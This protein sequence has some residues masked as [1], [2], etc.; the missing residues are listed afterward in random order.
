MADFYEDDE[1]IIMDDMMPMGPGGRRGG[2]GRGAGP[3]DVMF[4][5]FVHPAPAAGETVFLS[6]N[7]PELTN[8]V[9]MTV[10]PLG[11]GKL[12]TAVVQVNAANIVARH[13]GAASS[14]AAGLGGMGGML[15][16]LGG[17][18]DMGGMRGAGGQPPTF[19]Y[20]Y[21]VK[22]AAGR[23]THREDGERNGE[24][25]D[26]K[27]FYFHRAK[28]AGSDAAQDEGFVHFVHD[29][30][31]Q[32]QSGNI[33]PE[34][35]H[36]RLMALHS[37]K[38]SKQGPL[39]DKAIEDLINNHW[40][41][42]NAPHPQVVLQVASALG[43]IR[44]SRSAM[45]GWGMPHSFM[46]DAGPAGREKDKE[47]EKEEPPS[48]LVCRW[49][50]K[51]CPSREELDALENADAGARE[52]RPKNRRSDA[53]T[54]NGVR[55]AAET[56]YTKEQTFEWLKL[57]NFLQLHS[58]PSAKSASEMT[59][60][61]SKKLVASFVEEMET[62]FGRIDAEITALRA[63]PPAD[64]KE[65]QAKEAEVQRKS[66]MYIGG[67]CSF[68]PSA[69]SLERL[70]KRVQ[71][72]GGVFME[73]TMQNVF[74][75][76]RTLHFG[77]SDKDR[78]K[79]MIQA[80]PAMQIDECA[81]ALLQ[82][83]HHPSDSKFDAKEIIDFV[84]M[85]TQ[86]RQGVRPAGTQLQNAA[87]RWLVR[88]YGRPSTDRERKQDDKKELGDMSQKE[89]LETKKEVTLVMRE[90]I[91][92]WNMV[93]SV[94][95]F[96][97]EDETVRNLLFELS[98]SYFFKDQQPLLVLDCILD[99]E[100][101]IRQ[102]TVVQPLKI[103]VTRIS[104]KCTRDA[105]DESEQEHDEGLLSLLF[106][107]PTQMR[108]DVIE[109]FMGFRQAS[110]GLENILKN[111][112]IWAHLLQKQWL[113]ARDIRS[114]QLGNTQD[115]GMKQLKD[116]ASQLAKGTI[117]L[118]ALH[119]IIKYQANYESLVAQVAP[120]PTEIP[121]ST[122]KIRKFDEEFE[123]LQ[124]YVKMFCTIAQID[125]IE[126]S[127]LVEGINR[128]Y[129][130]LE[131]NKAAAK[132][133]GLPVR[134]HLPWLYS[135]RG[136]EVFAGI[137]KQ[138][139]RP[140][141]EADKREIKQDEVV[142]SII[143]EA[144][145]CWELLSKNIETGQAI[146]NDIRWVVNLQWVSVERE[147][148]LLHTTAP[149]SG[150]W[151]L[152]SGELCKSMRLAAKLRD[153]APGL[154]H[155]HELLAELF[156]KGGGKDE[157]VE[158]LQKV[159]L[160]YQPMWD[161]KLGE[162]TARVNPYRATINTVSDAMQDY[163]ITASHHD[164]SID[165][166]MK[167]SSTED[168]NR[169]M[170]ITTPNT[171]DSIILAA[172]ASLRQMRTFLAECLY[173]KPPYSGL[174][175]F[176]KEL[177]NL[178]VDDGEMKALSAV[179]QSFDK[180][181]DLLTKNSR[182]PGV[183]ACYDLVTLSEK[184]TFVVTCSTDETKQLKC[185]LEGTEQAWDYEFLAE[186]RRTLLMTDVP[187]E[188]EGTKDLSA[189]L[190]ALVQKLQL[191][192]DYGRCTMEL[193]QLGHFYYS[194]DQ[195][196]LEVPPKEPIQA[197]Q[198]CLD[199]QLQQLSDW[200]AAVNSARAEHYFLNYYTVR[201]LCFLTRLIPT[202]E[203][204]S[205]AW[206]KV[207]PLLRVIDV[208]ASPDAKKKELV[209]VVKSMGASLT[210]HGGNEVSVLNAIG[211]L[212]GELLSP[213]EPQVRN[214]EGLP[215]AKQLAQG[216]LLMRGMEQKSDQ[217]VPIFVC[218]ADE[219]SKVTELVLSIFTRRERV[220]ESEELLLCSSHTTL[221]EIDLLLRRFINARKHGRGD[222]LYCVANVHLLS[223]VTQCGTVEAL[224]NLE[225]QVGFS[226]AS[227]LV[228]VTGAHN[229][230]LT[231]ALNRYNLSV[232]VLPRDLLE[233]SVAS[234]GEKY[235]GKQLRA[236]ASKM[237]GVGKTHWIY[238]KVHEFQKEHGDQPV[239]HH[240][241]IR[242]NTNM[243]SLVS[244]LL[245]DPTDPGI[246]T[247]IH[248]DLAHIL[249]SHVDTLMF[250]LLIV[251]MLR[252]TQTCRVYHRRSKDFFFVEIPNTPGE[253]TER[254]LSF[255]LLL[256]REYLE[257]RMDCIDPE[258]PVLRNTP[259]GAT[260]V[261]FVKN[262]LLALVGKTLA[263]MKKEAFNPKSKQFEV[264]WTGKKS[265]E[266][267]ISETYQLLEEI[268]SSEQSPPSFLVFMN[269]VKF[270]GHLIE[271]AEGWN[272]MNLQ[273][274]Q[275]FDP[276]LK[277]FKHC[278]FR[279]LI[280]TSRDFALR[281]VPK[282]MDEVP[283]SVVAPRVPVL[284]RGMSRG[285]NDAG[286]AP[287]LV[288]GLSGL[289]APGLNRAL[290][291]GGSGRPG[292][293]R[294]RSRITEEQQARALADAQAENSG[295]GRIEVSMYVSRF[296]K[297]PSWESCVHPVANFKKNN[298]GMIIG[299]NIMSLRQ[300]FI[301]NFIDRNL[302]NSLNLND[303]KLDRDWSK[304]TH[305]DAV[306]LVHQ[307][308]GGE[309]LDKKDHLNG[310]KEYVVT[311]DNLIKL[312]SIQQR[313]KYLLPVIL[314]GE[315][316]CGKTALVKFLAQTLDF[317]LFTLDIHGGITDQAIMDHLDNAT[318]HAADEKGVLVFFD[319]INA[320][321]CMA[322]FKTVIIDRMYGNKHIPD[323]VRIISC[324]NPY[325][326]RKNKELE[327]VALVFQSAGTEGASAITDPMKSLVYRVHP[328]PESLIDVVSDFGS[329]SEASEEIYINAILRK[330]LPKL[331][332]PDEGAAAAAN[333]PQNPGGVTAA[334]GQNPYDI[335]IAILTELLCTS[336]CY[337]REV[338][339]GE[340]SVV[341][342]RDIGRAGRVFKWFLTYYAQLENVASPYVEDGTGTK[343]L[344]VSTEHRAHLRSAT[345]LTL[346]YCYHARLNRNQRWGYRKRLCEQWMK[347]VG[348]NKEVEWLDFSN[349][350]EMELM[351]VDTQNKFV[352]QMDLG[353]GIALNEALRENLF[354]LLVSIMNQ[355]PILLIGKPGCSK[356]LAM[357]TLQSNLNGEVSNKEFFKAMPAVD[358]FAYQCSP[359]STPDAILSAFH[360]ARQ[361]NLGHKG[362]I[363]CVLLD[364]V[365]L[366]EESPHMPLKVLHKELEDLRGIACVGISNWALDAAKMSRCVT[367]YRPP[368]TVE[369]LC[370]T[371]EGMVASA[372]LKGYLRA[373]SEAFAEIY[374]GQSRADFWGMR[375]FYSTV[376][377][378][379]A[380]LKIRAS[381][382]LE[383]VLEPQVLMKTVQRNFGGQP[384]QQMDD[385]LDEFFERTGMDIEKA[386]RF[387]IP[388]LIKQNMEE[389][390]ARHL[391]LLT[392]NNAA[393]RLLFEGG[394]LDH[395]KAEV[396]FGS[397]FS[398]DQS[399]LFVAMNLQ[400]IKTF[401]QQPISLVMVHCD[402]LYESL[403]DLLNQH[404]MEYAGQ[405]YVRIAHG[406]KAKQ[407]PIHRLFRVVVIT[408]ISDAYFRLAPPLLN[409]FEKQIFLR[410]DLMT[411]QDQKG[412]L[413]RVVKFW[414][415]LNGL[416]N[417]GDT[418]E[419][420]QD[421]VQESF[422]VLEEGKVTTSTKHRPMAGYHPEL[423]SSLVFTLRKRFPD[424][425]NDELF[426]IAKK[427]ISWVLTPEAVCIA[428][429]TLTRDDMQ[430]K[431]G[432]DLVQEYFDNQC[433]SDLPQ[434]VEMLLGNKDFWC[435]QSGAQTMIMTYSPI[436]G[437]VGAELNKVEGA[438]STGEL[439][440]HELTSSTDIEKAV[441]NFYAAAPTG[442]S[443]FFIIHADPAAASVRMIEHCRFVC[444][445]E[446]SKFIKA[447][448]QSSDKVF[449]VLVIH[450]QRGFDGKFSF[451]FDSQW[452][453]VFL[454][455]VEP[456]AELNSM[457]SL[458]EMLNMPLI[459]VVE[460]MDFKMLLKT[461]FR[462]SLSRL[463]YPHAR[464]PE[465]LQMQIQKLLQYIEDAE[466]VDML[467]E[468]SLNIIR[469]TPDKSGNATVGQDKHWFAAI[470]S[471]AN[472]LA[473]A[474][475][476]RAA[477]HN[478]IVNL[479]GSLTT[480][481]LAH[482]DRNGG[483][484]LLVQSP[485]R[486]L[487][488]KL[489]FASLTSPLSARLA[490]EAVIA[491]DEKGVEQHE[492]GTDAQTSAMPYTSRF[493]ASWFVSK[494]LDLFRAVI[495]QHPEAEQLSA[496]QAQYQLSKLSEIGINPALEAS[497]LEDYMHDFTAMHLD[498]TSRIDR[499]VQK[500][501]LQ[502][503][504]QRLQKDKLSS[505]LEIHQLFW[506]RERQITFYISLLNAVPGAVPGAEKIIEES[507]LSTLDLDLLLLVHETFV[508]EL[509]SAK[510][511]D[512]KFYMDWMMRKHIIAG[513]TKD[514][515]AGVGA[516]ADAIK[517]AK[518]KSNTEPR[519]ETLAFM[520]QHVALPLQ[521]TLNLV[522][523]FA[524]DL[525]K[526]KLRHSGT[527]LAALNFA[528][529]AMKAKG[530]DPRVLSQ[531]SAF[532][533]AFVLDVCLR[534]AEAA[535]DVEAAT[536]RLVCSMAAGLPLVHAP[537]TP[538]G[539]GAGELSSWSE[540]QDSGVAILSDKSIIPR[541]SSL[542]LA[543]LRKLIVSSDG[544]A[545]AA[546]TNC[547]EE[548][549]KTIA[550]HEKHNDTSFA[551]RY[552]IL[553]EEDREA[554]LGKKSAKEDPSTWPTVTL[555]E[556]FNSE[557]KA[558]PSMM[559]QKIGKVRQVLTKYAS[560]LCQEPI[561]VLLHEQAVL[562]VDKLLQ[563]SDPN[564]MSVCRSMR[565]FL[566]KCLE[567]R[568][569]VSFV[570]GILAESPLEETPWV[571]AWREL[572]DIDF[573]KFVGAALVPK[574]NPFGGKDSLEEYDAAMT[575]VL[576]MMN[577]T[578][579]VRLTKFAQDTSKL[580]E[581]KKKKAV[582][583]LLLALAQEPGLLAAL[584]EEDRRPPWRAPLHEWLKNS[585][586]LPVNDKERI[587]LR[588]F[589]GDDEPVRN[590]PEADQEFFMAFVTHDGRAGRKMDDLLRWRVLAHLAATLI[591][592]QETSLFNSLRIIM[593]EPSRL[594][595]GSPPFLPSMEED[596]RNRV[597][598]ALVEKGENIWKFKS[599]WYKC[600]C[601]YTFFIGE[602]GRPMETF[603][604]PQCAKE[605]G[606]RDHNQTANTTADDET[607]RSPWG[608]S[609]PP[610]EKDE[611]H[612]TFR[613]IQSSSA[614][615]IR[616]LLHG[617]MICG[618]MANQAGAP[619]TQRTF[620]DLVNNESM[621]TMVQNNEA[622]YL[623]AH[624]ANDWNSMVDI[625]SSN[626]EDLSV[627]LH[628]LIGTMVRE[629][630]HSKDGSAP[631]S[632]GVLDL[633]KRNSWEDTIEAKFLKPLMK[634]Y[635]NSLQ[636]LYTEWSGEQEDGKFV[637][638]IKEAA[639]VKLFP[640]P[641]REV[642][643]PQLWAYRSPVTLDSLHNKLGQE[644]DSKETLPVL[645]EVLREPLCNI[646][647]ALGQLAGVFEWQ[648][649][650]INHFS[651]RIT[652]ADA[653]A[654][655]IQDVFDELPPV[656]RGRWE[657]AFKCF[658]LAWRYAMPYAEYECL[659]V[660]E[661]MRSLRINRDTA[662]VMCIPD[663]K[664]DGLY[665][666]MIIDWLV[667]RHNEIVRIVAQSLNYPDRYISSRLLAQHDLIKYS[668][669]ELMRFL[670][671]RCVT[672]GEGGKLN[673]NLKQLEYQLR[674]EL[675][676]PE[677]ETEMRG[678]QWLGDAFSA[679]NEMKEAVVQ[680]DLMPDTIE[681]IKMELSSPAMASFCLQ[682]VQMSISFI[683]KSGSSLGT[684]HAGE[685]L[686]AD[687]MRNVLCETNDSLPSSC[688]R[689]EVRLTHVDCFV[690]VLRSLVNKDP[691]DGVEA[692]YKAELP[693][694]LAKPLKENKA[695]APP[696]LVEMMATFAESRLT[697][698]YL[699]EN[700]GIFSIV[701]SLDI[702]DSEASE[703]VK[704]NM[705]DESYLL[706]HWAAI[707]R[708]LKS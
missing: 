112:P 581:A 446:R 662:L 107:S 251:G 285:M 416:M 17:L 225:E 546:A 418:E 587:L 384:D 533:E 77:Q 202:V 163:L 462:S 270:L 295:A 391:M 424:K 315:T 67:L 164:G 582:G 412:L 400:R 632:W 449:V 577:T 675:A 516:D 138:T 404:Y 113:E 252:D 108:Y 376:R 492:V 149:R 600:T 388:D 561:D 355:I 46:D 242:E 34:E 239:M 58:L 249:P 272:M 158:E 482:L 639:D 616:M 598:K 146:L 183:Q 299:C 479:L 673:Y 273:L 261:S 101:E 635:E 352:S 264:T 394:L 316:G 695:S 103:E 590:L 520:L 472:E 383:A 155:L 185:K 174:R 278:F 340:R 227:A 38:F 390:D 450:L 372:N 421:A 633:A 169:L 411:N 539:I 427:S 267:D 111:K 263:A 333:A 422:K 706:K 510:G 428:A 493:P 526:D 265:A 286:I 575:A 133:D 525:P 40:G 29:E 186:L 491:I 466:F 420:A 434:F 362:T 196:V 317:R 353:E 304:V 322:L 210:A 182:S 351:M 170:Q 6:G 702:L 341:S 232:T 259:Q 503:T 301:G 354:M 57:L 191:L 601:G 192:E 480:A 337:V 578:S 121:A 81:V 204:N 310:P 625:L 95:C 588:V 80:M 156:P 260:V 89:Y 298:R 212:L 33:T 540:N 25:G 554:S 471:A 63:N 335:F 426:E 481:V 19:E 478:R 84:K 303:L 4:S 430:R 504:I 277:N 689:S 219:A 521:L 22:D 13:G 603:K 556:I 648:Q 660:P 73:V 674:K 519:V 71:T 207:W 199:R 345:V 339:E 21:T 661:E 200:Q 699:G 59:P 638:E 423:M 527:M 681:R 634:N 234:V 136:S 463:I 552:A 656:D 663:S 620:N 180:M 460:G 42:D 612:V 258:M 653:Q 393:L 54:S 26:V 140:D 230:M 536:L 692:K 486:E 535:N 560:I 2:R 306:Q 184:G 18:G 398:S 409:R 87:R 24:H 173:T 201:E 154:L 231:N 690:K 584:E 363:V 305:Q 655:S 551:T 684:H 626:T 223:Y 696:S 549:L 254:Q 611:K 291:G 500:R 197:V 91:R 243:A 547:I 327:D 532:L 459:Q 116:S 20:G 279:L 98:Q 27:S 266:I 126:L 347:S 324:C 496:L 28:F 636:D 262:T 53:S 502:K 495:E 321:N 120:K 281:Q 457:P 645:N 389:P 161:M 271:S 14:S 441:Q 41:Y 217:G 309:L 485:K 311:V 130:E 240:V 282:L 567:R 456:S 55:F 368:P 119:T 284:H 512:A 167:H 224:R 370:I 630:S 563:S 145:R 302:Q 213:V 694:D 359:L 608:Y 470:A 367:L 47:K 589:A 610:V 557:M 369:D 617:A 511:D 294:Q 569:G 438:Q 627:G 114:Y 437:K 88:Y 385:N 313:L 642:E 39:L 592:A 203:T 11:N 458:G 319:E 583:G 215:Q 178:I 23:V 637:A 330:E 360:T 253:N 255:C 397:T 429:A 141:D 705:P 531:F 382:G 476:F 381:Q 602:C 275:N 62:I 331:Q 666:L 125:A 131:L 562:K 558:N 379:N 508:G 374:K 483:L 168:F 235:H 467:R 346:G 522:A 69:E 106:Q 323:N 685:M 296:D 649:L 122:A 514:F 683:L 283:N 654:K 442:K 691:M 175:E 488:L 181:H 517:L 293:T 469:T 543:L 162:M 671:S 444:E 206:E 621:C 7:L 344:D 678:F 208:N 329:L 246:P 117:H 585:Q 65:R 468:W 644:T 447:S 537:A 682:K 669:N 109:A 490:N 3:M 564:L 494:S 591:A 386:E 292:L 364:E 342:M 79:D 343:K 523:D 68:C 97:V 237:N 43:I 407:C 325:R 48:L 641:K 221:E 378:I 646:L 137:W 401:M 105:Q 597:L 151:L 448:S 518:L 70:V 413:N 90:A 451:D 572:H 604:C 64:D 580:P 276:G 405:R 49:V 676:R 12:W 92:G 658:E 100:N 356:S 609:L 396:M 320:A 443:R 414:D 104:I 176:I 406:S 349:A 688:A 647:P 708:I 528:Q 628:N 568:R 431:F 30:I 15:G 686:L 596:I 118:R 307:I 465:D 399:D 300:D 171:D 593:L 614:R 498:W 548:L 241:E 395:S 60:A 66:E 10:K 574:W 115:H 408:E 123:H 659:Q 144:K 387:T 375:E 570:R 622:Q 56:L 37:S 238:R 280:E 166:L 624:F 142:S 541:S 229:Q 403:Y 177:G 432:F 336:Q 445:K 464:K 152:A 668:K 657:D 132:F 75:R 613:E 680:R 153:W 9:P 72:D 226:A 76:L 599:H 31:F 524:K 509:V 484:D 440:L 670:E 433:H 187:D 667:G 651:G 615:A 78:L 247:A 507:E 664:D 134:Q 350:K 453:S 127:Q 216:D 703:W 650:C 124:T 687:Y 436:R 595:A 139:A 222:R 392:K 665:A 194:L 439:S 129:P 297:M 629:Q 454:D 377:V 530:Q 698:S 8:G 358:V 473:Q 308:E 605:I 165:W 497:L 245:A 172:L 5:V 147:L 94:P 82:N 618:M 538:Q 461:C 93:L 677:I 236:V 250:E 566:L 402:S 102:T 189:L 529:I 52:G 36:K 195:Q 586:D 435:D 501:I 474:G 672:W 74:S 623:T 288:R 214:L 211:K 135:L 707:Y 179:Q 318:R 16:M 515:L 704:A 489:S 550:K 50:V 44:T 643:M 328:L 190:D 576:E 553:Q 579:T 640:A 487:W 455:S 544:A 85:I 157:C 188:L 373:L 619:P 205:E 256:P 209:K 542:N 248:I 652:K 290:S 96:A 289:G 573:E 366:A 244:T 417:Q 268:C 274:L 86:N 565:L 361:S 506:S 32:L 287:E 257:M 148:N 220:P 555:D 35:S 61:E 452:T 233:T 193:F 607:D 410:K 357:E 679:G 332:D 505:I 228:F 338:N 571:M 477:L 45:H 701:D 693:E 534:D 380:E 700:Y 326:R 160:E 697:E 365:G 83:Q 1:D 499:G 314:M 198:E 594:M 559:L 419:D 371:A 143:P 475:T 51:H 415:M 159:V 425:I 99:L 269:L 312:M 513:L 631:A 128:S 348:K 334:A 150:E 110:Q 545:K 218:A 606:G